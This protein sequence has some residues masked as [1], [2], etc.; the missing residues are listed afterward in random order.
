MSCQCYQGLLPTPPPSPHTH[1]SFHVGQLHVLH[2][3]TGHL[4]RLIPALP[5]D[6]LIFYVDVVGIKQTPVMILSCQVC[7]NLTIFDLR[8]PDSSQ[9]KTH[10]I[11][12]SIARQA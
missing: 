5:Q 4:P 9:H 10:N 7:V 8:Y 12:Y 6:L 11:V 1:P 2:N 3:T